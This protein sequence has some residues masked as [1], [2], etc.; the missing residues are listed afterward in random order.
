MK[1]GVAFSA[2]ETVK[3]MKSKMNK[4]SKGRKTLMRQREMSQ[5][6]EVS[7]FQSREEESFVVIGGNIE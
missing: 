2:K 5:G 6:A 7:K 3:M 4:K 1:K